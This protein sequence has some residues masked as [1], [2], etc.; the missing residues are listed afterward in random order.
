MYNFIEIFYF[1]CLYYLPTMF[2]K[3]L[4]VTLATA[5]SDIFEPMYL[6]SNSRSD[7]GAAIFQ[8]FNVCCLQTPKK[9][10]SHRAACVSSFTDA[11]GG[12][13]TVIFST[14]PEHLSTLYPGAVMSVV[15]IF[16]LPTGALISRYYKLVFNN[17]FKVTCLLF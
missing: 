11:H 16:F 1:L 14:L 3:I 4:V 15:F 2:T 7:H 13:L 6:I 9:A 5:D 8:G 17:W 12:L 10:V